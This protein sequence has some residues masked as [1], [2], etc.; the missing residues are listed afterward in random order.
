MRRVSCTALLFAALANPAAA[1]DTSQIEHKQNELEQMRARIQALQERLGA[2]RVQRGSLQGELAA[3]ERRLGQIQGALRDADRQQAALK[4][5]LARLE[6]DKTSQLAALDNQRRA[7]ARSLR[8]AHTLGREGDAKV[9]LNHEQPGTLARTLTYHDYIRR[10]YRARLEAVSSTLTTLAQ[11]EQN[12][13]QQQEQLSTLLAEQ[14]RQQDALLT[15]KQA[16]RRLLAQLD[17][18]ISSDEQRLRELRDN[19]SALQN[20]I[21]ELRKALASAPPDTPAGRPFA[22]LKGQLSL[23]TRGALSAR[24]GEPRQLGR[25]KWQ[26][27]VIASEEGGEV[28]A[29]AAG[30]VVFADWLRGYGL[31]LIVDH[32]AGYMS[33]Y[34]YNQNLLKRTGE[35]VSDREVIANVGNSGGNARPGLYF[36]IR[37]QGTPLNPLQWCNP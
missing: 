10:E 30:R 31:L 17:A 35:H 23:P 20:L 37:H 18:A 34:G 36:E 5:Q 28:H 19:E 21:G 26:G 25:L 15:T 9:I 1:A 7:L 22:K 4:N 27:V 33:L 11:V 2:Q 32:G 6:R 3:T 16:R 14:T 8:A 13:H 24:Y 29:V 12:I